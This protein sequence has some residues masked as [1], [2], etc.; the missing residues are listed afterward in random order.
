MFAKKMMGFVLVGL[1][2][3]SFGCAS[4]TA[5]IGKIGEAEIWEIH[6]EHLAG[7]NITAVMVKEKDGSMHRL[8]SYGGP[9]AGTAIATSAIHAAGFAGGTIGAAA[10]LRPDNYN[11][12]N[13]SVVG[14]GGTGGTGTGGNA[15][16]KAKGGNAAASAAN[17]NSNT[18][19][20][21]NTAKGGKGGAGGV[22]QGGNGGAGGNGGNGNHFG[23]GNNNGHHNDD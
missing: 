13:V 6:S 21:T 8:D 19:T 20:N 12:G 11:G 22:G 9:G 15:S 10:V 5:M 7:P 2:S 1:F 4:K 14:G 17:V 3:L 18:N 23:P 16:A